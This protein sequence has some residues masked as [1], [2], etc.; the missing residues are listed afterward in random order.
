MVKYVNGDLFDSDANI[1]AHGCNTVGGYGS[2]VAK[3]MAENFPA[4]KMSYYNK[5]NGEGWKLGD[6]QFVLVGSLKYV[7]NCATQQEY[8]PRNR[9]HADYDA[10]RT[11]MEKVKNFAKV[12]GL[13]IAIPK[14]GAG[15][16]GGDWNTIEA[17]LNEVFTD[18][19]VTVFVL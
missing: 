17:I 6:V 11:C 7:V 2:G 8:Y 9:V 15:L 18:Y 14:I 13:T 10:I 16:A 1:L 4:A 19:D 5:Y 12:G 3:L